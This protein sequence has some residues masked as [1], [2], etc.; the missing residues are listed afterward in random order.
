MSEQEKKWERIYDLLDI[1]TK[2]KVWFYLLYTKQRKN[3]FYQKQP[4]KWKVEW[5][6]EQ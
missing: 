6:I 1:E 5:K 3:F 2:L 4:F